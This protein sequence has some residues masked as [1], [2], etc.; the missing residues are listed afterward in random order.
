MLDM[1]VTSTAVQNKNGCFFLYSISSFILLRESFDKL[2]YLIKT[3]MVA[4]RNAL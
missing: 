4:F 2:I 1:D 3:T